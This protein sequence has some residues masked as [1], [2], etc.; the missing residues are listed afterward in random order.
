MNVDFNIKELVGAVYGLANGPRSVMAGSQE[1]SIISSVYIQDNLIDEDIV[2]PLISGLNEHY[3]AFILS[4][5]G[6]NQHIQGSRTV[7]DLLSVISTESFVS[8]VDIAETFGRE[9]EVIISQEAKLVELDSRMHKFISGKLIEVELS[10][11]TTRQP[12]QVDMAKSASEFA[13]S[14]RAAGGEAPKSI[15]VQL[16]VQLMPY[17]IPT[18]AAKGFL[19]LNAKDDWIRRTLRMTVGQI[20]F[21]R[22]FVFGVDQSVEYA[23]SLKQAPEHLATMMA[24]RHKKMRNIGKV[25]AGKDASQNMINSVLIVDSETFTRVCKEKH[26]NFDRQAIR[27]KFFEESM[28]MIVVVV[29]REFN[30]VEIYYHGI[31]AIAD[32]S[33]DQVNRMGAASDSIGVKEIMNAMVKNNLPKF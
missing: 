27:D 6:L 19:G 8:A 12:L 21:W 18:D 23:K 29:D 26:I 33:Y 30:T 32:Y 14:N 9:E 7:R 3:C 28:C 15:K 31:S 11:V 20:N 16:M 17:E 1:A 24:K 10:T 25:L 22:D 4:C 13:S 2:V 5:L